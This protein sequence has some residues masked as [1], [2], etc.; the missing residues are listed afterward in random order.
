MSRSLKLCAALLCL[1]AF[2]AGLAL[3]QTGVVGS[4]KTSANEFILPNGQFDLDAAP[5]PATALRER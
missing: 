2:L 5:C 1:L 3:A 4:Q